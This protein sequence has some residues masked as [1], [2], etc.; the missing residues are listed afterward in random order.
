MDSAAATEL[1]TDPNKKGN[2]SSM[3]IHF[4]THTG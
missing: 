3:T 2:G 1:R 4:L